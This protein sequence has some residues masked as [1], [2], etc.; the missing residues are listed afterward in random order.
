MQLFG[1]KAIGQFLSFLEIIDSKEGVIGHLVCN[2]G[3]G[4]APG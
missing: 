1:I 2:A 3:L 4:Q